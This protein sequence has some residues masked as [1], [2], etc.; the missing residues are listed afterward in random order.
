MAA[1][2]VFSVAGSSLGEVKSPW[3]TQQL[4]L[5]PCALLVLW[6]AARALE[7]AWLRPR[8][9]GRALRAQGLQGTAYRSPAGDGSLNE[10]LVREARAATLPP[11]CHDVVPRVM[12]LFHHAMKE[13]GDV[14]IRH[15]FPVFHYR[16]T[17]LALAGL[18]TPTDTFRPERFC[19][20]FINICEL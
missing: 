1:T 7:W 13:H 18:I 15:S 2:G 10:R 9:L 11:G 6:C 5:L 3:K 17:C 12:P 19:S 4:L 16:Y 14:S 20:P 8:R